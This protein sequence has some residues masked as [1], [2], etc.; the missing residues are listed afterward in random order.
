MI[1]ERIKTSIA[2]CY[3]YREVLF[4]LLSQD[5]KIRYRRTTLGYLWSLL[6]PILQ[7]AVLS[8]V[9]SQ[10]T[11]WGMRDYTLYLFSGFCG[12][13]FIQATLM[14]GASLIFENKGVF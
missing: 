1:A 11:R 4:N 8:A 12:W 2:D 3:R 14:A 5:L 13:N 7:L 6:N 9:F 10:L